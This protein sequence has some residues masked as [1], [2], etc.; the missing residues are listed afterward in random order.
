MTLR[1]VCSR[2]V[3]YARRTGTLECQLSGVISSEYG[4]DRFCCSGNAVWPEMMT[5][6][7]AKSEAEAAVQM[8]KDTN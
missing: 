8:G 3:E 2:C 1:A 6:D 4:E 7:S 5:F